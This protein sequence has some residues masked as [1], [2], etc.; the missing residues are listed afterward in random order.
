MS[1]IAEHIAAIRASLPASVTLVAVSKYHPAEDIATAYQAGQR[2]FAES[3]VAELKAKEQALRSTCPDIRWHFIGH[4]QTN[5][6]RDL[7][8]IPLA[9]VQSVDSVRLLEEMEK[10]AAKQDKMVDILL[11]LHMAKEESKTGFENLDDIDL[12]RYP[13]LRLRGLMTMATHTESI[14]ELHRCF[15]GA[16]EVLCTLDLAHPILSMGM[17]D[18]YPIAIEEGSTMVRI[19]SAIFGERNY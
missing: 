19:G 9:L 10:E 13:H 17:S 4:L 8:R 3:R 5:K 7:L 2:D 1:S 11:E 12:T 18:D 16:K 15:R 14:P 6:V